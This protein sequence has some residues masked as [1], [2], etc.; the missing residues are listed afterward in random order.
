[1]AKDGAVAAVALPRFQGALTARRRWAGVGLVL[2]GAPLLA[3]LLS[4]VHDSSTITIEVLAFQLLIVVVAL[5][6]GIWPALL[7]AVLSA[8]ILDLFFI[9]PHLTVAVADP[10]HVI[11]LV[12]HIV[13]AVLVS[14]VVDRAAHETIEHLRLEET[15]SEIE[16][17]AASD[18]A[19][20]S[21][22]SALSHDIRRPLASATAAV[23]GIRSAEDTLSLA[24]RR[25]LLATAEESLAALTHLVTDLLDVSRLEAGVMTIST[26]PCDPI[27]VI[28]PALDELDVDP[29]AVELDLEH[30]S[31]TMLADPVLLQRA[32]VNLLANALRFSPVGSPVTV[33][34]VVAGD[35]LEIRVI[36]HG[37]GI[38]LE[39][40]DEVFVPFQRRG[41]VDNG[42]GLG[43]GL[44]LSRGFV[45]VMHGSIE[46]RE[47]PGG[48]L[49]MVVALPVGARRGERR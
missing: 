14:Y 38:A 4:R 26:M 2:V 20:A 39:R 27:D 24:D 18:R 46:P 34:T 49:T 37:P 32:V 41:D 17:L 21:L 48:G 33:V 16:P 35:R 9:E 5:V 8:L 10:V 25:E 3:W 11:T 12:F 36:D 22:L 13:I 42:S 43:L 6:G 29:G 47:T 19:R 30:G 40:R 44:A 15:V 28:I 23:S 45:E 7:A 31:A 1:M